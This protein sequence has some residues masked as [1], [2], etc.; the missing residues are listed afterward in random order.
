VRMLLTTLWHGNVYLGAV[1]FPVGVDPAKEHLEWLSKSNGHG[2]PMEFLGWLVARGCK[3]VGMDRKEAL[4]VPNECE[5]WLSLEPDHCISYRESLVIEYP[6]LSDHIVEIER[7][8]MKVRYGEDNSLTLKQVL[9]FPGASACLTA[10]QNVKL[11]TEFY[12]LKDADTVP[13]PAQEDT[14]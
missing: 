8:L 13:S 11:A 7:A 3:R 1:S 12:R 14:S 2:R 4:R 10:E 9:S 6:F 5:W